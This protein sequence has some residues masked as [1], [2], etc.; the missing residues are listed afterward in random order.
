MGSGPLSTHL[1]HPAR[2]ERQR[3]SM[4]VRDRSRAD[5]GCDLFLRLWPAGMRAPSPHGCVHGESQKEIATQVGQTA[6]ACLWGSSGSDPRYPRKLKLQDEANELRGWI[7]RPW[8]AGARRKCP[9]GR[10]VHGG[11]SR[12]SMASAALAHPCAACLRNHPRNSC[13]LSDI[14][15]GNSGPDPI[16]PQAQDFRT[17]FKLTV[18]AL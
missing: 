15:G 18:G 8:P 6:C 13:R 17:T 16:S 4:L 7:L 11:R 2:A 5:L 1:I 3:L 14:C 9:W 10:C 12:P